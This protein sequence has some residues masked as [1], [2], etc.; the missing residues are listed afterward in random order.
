MTANI[1][2]LVF[3]ILSLPCQLPGKVISLQFGMDTTILLLVSLNKL[4]HAQAFFTSYHLV[5]NQLILDNFLS[6][7]LPENLGLLFHDILASFIYII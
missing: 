4:V 1:L 2:T 3:I 6:P 5:Q 7:M